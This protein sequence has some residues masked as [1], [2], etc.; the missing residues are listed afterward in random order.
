MKDIRWED[1]EMV[2]QE[3][4]LAS[5]ALSRIYISLGRPESPF[6]VSGKKM[7]DSIIKAWEFKFPEE[8][9]LW[10][11][12]RDEYQEEEM[13][14]RTQVRKGTGRTIVSYPKMIHA[15]L[16]FFFPDEKMNRTFHMK[17]GKNFDIFRF[18]NKL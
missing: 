18:A 5:D 13:S 14:I 2:S 7:V 9:N 16:S 1:Y 10:K 4:W 15:L 12:T 6:T 11:A 3:D 8:V 17:M